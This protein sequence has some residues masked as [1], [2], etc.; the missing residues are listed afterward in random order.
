VT[1]PDVPWAKVT[2]TKAAARQ[3]SELAG[4]V[5]RLLAVLERIATGQEVNPAEAAQR[6]LDESLVSDL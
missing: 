6:A 3:L 1:N 4:E 2:V 5:E